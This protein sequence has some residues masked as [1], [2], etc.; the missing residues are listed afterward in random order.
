MSADPSLTAL[1]DEVAAWRAEDPDPGTVAELDALVIAV[2]AGDHEAE[3]RLRSAFAGPLQFGTAGLRAPMGPGPARM[4]RVVVSRAAAGLG[5]YLRDTGHTGGRVLV[6][7]DARHH[8]ARFALDTAEILAGQ[9]FRTLLVE[10]PAPTPLVSFGIRHLGCVAAVV[11]TASHNPAADNGYKVYLGD[12]SQ[13]IPP[14]DTEIAARIAD[15]AEQALPT[16]PRSDD[17]RPTEPSLLEAYVA[18]AAALFSVPRPPAL[19]PD[20][21]RPLRWIYTPMHG[22][23]LETVRRLVAAAGLPS[24]HVVAAQAEPDA[25]FP[26]VAFPNPEEPGA[27]DLAIALAAAEKADLVVAND[28]DAD[29]CA[30]AIPGPDGW[31]ML[32]GDELGVLLGADLLA[33]GVRG[34]YA[35]T[36]VSS[37]LLGTL[38]RAV[39]ATYVTTLTGF[40]W[41]GR[42]PGLVYGY[43]EALGY[44]TDPQVVPDKDGITTLVRVLDLAGR[45]AAAGRTLGDLLD[46]VMRTH[47]LH[48]TD[49]LAFRSDRAEVISGAMMRLRTSTPAT[50]LGEELTVTDLGRG[51]VDLPPTDAIVLE[52]RTLRV[53]VRPSGTEPKLKCYLEV[54]STPEASA[55]LAAARQRAAERLAMLGAEV[56]EALGLG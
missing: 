52:G 49:Q 20:S 6:G 40:K 15:A 45:G 13:I 46:E 8:S 25:D 36:V 55:D 28:P 42:V 39:G 32:R 34:T 21:S 50:L 54:R 14:I 41:I 27:L 51:T 24:P 3:A 11:V 17:W 23:G 37:T 18:R 44:C 53:V 47:G 38:A 35:T 9:G 7:H 30:V 5:H 48:A 2:H 29:R 31:R 16:L 43:E 10:G 19:L 33:R 56:T 22:V 26:T 1:L 12:G 4:N